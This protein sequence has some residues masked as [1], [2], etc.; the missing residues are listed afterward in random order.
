MEVIRIKKILKEDKNKLIEEQALQILKNYLKNNGIGYSLAE[1]DKTPYLDGKIYTDYRNYDVQV[2]GV[3]SN[4]T[5]HSIKS[6][7]FNFAQQN[8]ILYIIVDNVLNNDVHSNIYYKVINAD[9]IIKSLENKTKITV[10]KLEF[11]K[12]DNIDNFKD[13]IDNEFHLFCK[14][15]SVGIDLTPVIASL[16]GGKIKADIIFDKNNEIENFSV[17][18]ISYHDEKTGNEFSSKIDTS[19]SEFF[20][21]DYKNDD[22]LIL[23]NTDIQ[24]N[25]SFNKLLN[26]VTLKYEDLKIEYN[27]NNNKISINIVNI[28]FDVERIELYQNYMTIIKTLDGNKNLYAAPVNMSFEQYID[29]LKE[30]KDFINPK[31]L[32]YGSF[33]MDLMMLLFNNLIK[34]ESQQGIANINGLYVRYVVANNKVQLIHVPTHFKIE[35]KSD[36]EFYFMVGYTA[37]FL[38]YTTPEYFLNI[39][40]IDYLLQL[41]LDKEN[42]LTKYKDE[43][44][45]ALIFNYLKI[46]WTYRKDIDLIK[47][48]EEYTRERVKTTDLPSFYVN[49]IQLKKILDMD[50]SG[51]ELDNLNNISSIKEDTMLQL[52]VHTVLENKLLAKNLY[53]GLDDESKETFNNYPIYKLYESLIQN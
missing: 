38:D 30:F 6:E 39:Y 42:I 13:Y 33:D 28:N 22:I 37:I 27:H 5:K 18:S 47:T 2:K 44:I 40:N 50:L 41:E 1:N 46:Y 25:R 52:C 34:L 15:I 49:Y 20:I 26:I 12:L 45:S 21:K 36:N 8:F 14:R 17:K 19:N 24:L 51:D 11:N 48:L 9:D 53:I 35:F 43:N 31:N 4:Y 32:K 23:P 29:K 7:Y 3:E 10:N 16:P